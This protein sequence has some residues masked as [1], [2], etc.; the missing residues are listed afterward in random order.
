MA[1]FLY[2]FIFIS[3]GGLILS[4]VVHICALLGIDLGLGQKV[5]GLHIGIFLVWIPT[6][7]VA[8]NLSKDCRRS[9]YW[10]VALRG[11]PGWMKKMTYGFFGY[12][13]VN[14]IFF[15]F[16]STKVHTGSVT[17]EIIRGFSGHWMAFY[18][19]ALVVLYSATQVKNA[20]RLK[21]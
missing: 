13:I 2:L 16:F 18:S 7:L 12:A 9:D 4:L 11:C 8:N 19:A 10:K 1:A 5:F 3:A 15:M 21:E 17:P 20:E 6:V 14:F